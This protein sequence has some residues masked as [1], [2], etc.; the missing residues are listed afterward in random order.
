[1]SATPVTELAPSAPNGWGFVY[2]DL[3][4]FTPSPVALNQLLR[5]AGTRS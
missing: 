4:N 5:K 2:F 3:I 1:M